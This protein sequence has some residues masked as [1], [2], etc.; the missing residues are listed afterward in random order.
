M[1]YLAFF[2]SRAMGA[3]YQVKDNL[4]LEISFVLLEYW[5]IK[6]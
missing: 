5:L 3:L 2:G 1:F 6:N 4:I